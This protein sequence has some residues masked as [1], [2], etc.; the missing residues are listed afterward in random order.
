[1]NH[2]LASLRA[3]LALLASRAGVRTPRLHIV[4]V[5]EPIGA[6]L[7]L[8]GRGDVFLSRG[9]LERLDRSEAAA[10]LAHEVAHLYHHDAALRLFAFW[11]FGL[12]ALWA[13]VVYATLAMPGMGSF[14]A[15][16]SWLGAL[17]VLRAQEWRADQTGARLLGNPEVLARA[18]E[19]VHGG[20]SRAWLGGLFC[21]HPPP[22]QRAARLR[23]MAAAQA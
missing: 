15:L 4:P 5:K 21:T 16:A 18:V 11:A 20:S 12:A 22:G 2:D 1:M 10:V 8:P 7:A 3:D 19:K 13:G 6:V 14:A 9:L 17:S 23:E